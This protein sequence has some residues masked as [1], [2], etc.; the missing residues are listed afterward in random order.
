[1]ESNQ[2]FALTVLEKMFTLYLRVRSFSFVKDLAVKK[3]KKK[4]TNKK[5]KALRKELKRS[6]EGN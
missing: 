2:E 5:E 3:D 6:K 4:T 1:M